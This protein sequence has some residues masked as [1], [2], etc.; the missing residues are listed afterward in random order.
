[1][2]NPPPTSLPSLYF[3]DAFFVSIQA[4]YRSACSHWLGSRVRVSSD[5]PRLCVL[6]IGVNSRVF[7]LRRAE[8]DV[9]AVE[10]I[11]WGVCVCVCVCACALRLRLR[12]L[13]PHRHLAFCSC[14]FLGL[15]HTNVGL[16]FRWPAAY[17][18]RHELRYGVSCQLPVRVLSWDAKCCLDIAGFCERTNDRRV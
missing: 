18:Y 1:M 6:I 8:Q 11:C 13:F 14:C 9:V 7:V 4:S 16:C 10:S 5:R 12:L 17:I 3:L 15:V 2:P